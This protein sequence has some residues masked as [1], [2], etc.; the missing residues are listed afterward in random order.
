MNRK[1]LVYNVTFFHNDWHLTTTIYNVEDD[2]DTI[3]SN[4]YAYMLNGHAMDL[5]KYI[6]THIEVEYVGE[7][8]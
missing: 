1:I 3:I 6:F 5:S 8:L 7:A 2:E 4:A